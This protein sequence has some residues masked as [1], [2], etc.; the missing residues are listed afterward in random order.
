MNTVMIGSVISVS[1]LACLIGAT[2]AENPTAAVLHPNHIATEPATEF[3][4]LDD[5]GNHVLNFGAAAHR[6]RLDSTNKIRLKFKAFGSSHEY[7]LDRS[8]SMLVSETKIYKYK[9][10]SYR[11]FEAPEEAHSFSSKDAALTFLSHNKIMG[12]VVLHNR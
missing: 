11:K 1:V 10:G 4:L 8:P 3:S 12:S 7:H 9:D 6:R 2:M 5:F